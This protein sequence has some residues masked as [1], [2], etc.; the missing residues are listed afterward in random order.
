MKITRLAQ[1]G[2]LAAVA[3]VALAGCA[4]S[5]T[6]DSS[7]ASASASID[8]SLSGTV[9]AGGSSAQANA[10]TA[11]AAAFTSV[12][13]GVTI[14]YDKT[15]GS[16]G[17]RTNFIAGS[18]D[19]AG[20]DAPLTADETTQAAA[21]YTSG[22]VNLPIYL[23][24]VAV[25][26]NSSISDTLNLSTETIA[27]IFSGQITNWSDDA[28]T[29]DNGGT[30]LAD[31][32]INVVVRSDS[33]GTANNFTNFL[34]ASDPTDWTWEGSGT[35]PADI[36][37]VDAQKGG[38]AVATEIAGVAGS[39]GY[40][41]N[42]ALIDGVSAASVNGIELTSDAVSEAF[43]AGATENSNGVDGDLSLA[44]D[45]DAINEDADAYPIP[46]LSYAIIPL[47]FTDTENADATI[48]Y[49][50]F[51]ATSTGQQ[52]A[53]AKANSVP[54]PQSILDEVQATLATVE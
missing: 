10:Q 37:G 45:Y 24:G 12:A 44:F 48:A 17:G 46:L 25:A 42:S 33:S 31:Q 9:T 30:A 43:T 26:Y 52:V 21:T 28:I 41:D 1:V 5:S 49:L 4:S 2:A 6:S 14:N 22:A 18:L 35:F 27:K 13:T 47:E 39:I 16:G 23:D 50:Q 36:T 19:F 51:I 11:W 32:A 34:Y 7:S 54:L 29:A 53:A 38:G 3:A 15:L 20:S 8:A 40:L